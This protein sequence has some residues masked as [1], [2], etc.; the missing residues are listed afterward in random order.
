ML[1]DSRQIAC[2]LFEPERMTMGEV[3]YSLCMSAALALDP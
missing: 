2:A 1:L 3:L